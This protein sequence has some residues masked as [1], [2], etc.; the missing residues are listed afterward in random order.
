[1]EIMLQNWIYSLYILYQSHHEVFQD[2]DP[3]IPNNGKI[4]GVFML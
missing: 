1:M 2:M 4:Q 3:L